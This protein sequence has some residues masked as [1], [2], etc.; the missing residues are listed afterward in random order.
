MSFS[1]MLEILQEMNEGR[2][3]MINAEIFYIA[4]GK[5]AVILNKELG[6]KCT[7]FTNYMCKV[8][9]PINSIEKYLQKLE[10]MKYGYIVDS[11]LKEYFVT[12]MV[13]TIQL[14]IVT[15]TILETATTN[16]APATSENH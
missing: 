15:T 6:L 12:T 7:C 2:I 4:T 1:N 5:D 14:S 8:G 16:P 3:V 10:K 13:Q 11:F 9:V